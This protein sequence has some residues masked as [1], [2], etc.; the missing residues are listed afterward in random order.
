M[1][2]EGRRGSLEGEKEEGGSGLT[3]RESRGERRHSSSRR[4]SDTCSK[5]AQR[6]AHSVKQHTARQCGQ[7]RAERRV[8]R[9]QRGVVSCRSAPMLCFSC[10]SAAAPVPAPRVALLDSLLLCVST[11][12]LTWEAGSEGGVRTR[13]KRREAK[14]RSEA[15]KR[16]KQPATKTS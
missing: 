2:A 5:D 11:A 14:E 4:E 12:G 7:C 1:R 10:C 9:R 15:E 3:D 13:Q 8:E 16:E 6:N